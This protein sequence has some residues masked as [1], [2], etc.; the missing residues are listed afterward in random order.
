MARHLREAG[1]PEW[2]YYARF[3]H[4]LFRALAGDR[5]DEVDEELTQLIDDMR[6]AGHTYRDSEQLL[7]AYR[8]LGEASPNSLEHDALC[9]HAWAIENPQGAEPMIRTLWLL[10]ACVHRR[11]ELALTLSDAIFRRL[12]YQVPFVH[13]ADHLF[14]RGFAAAHLA[15]STRG[16]ARLRH[17]RALARCLTELRA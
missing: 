16:L 1:D 3:L 10:L 15:N 7:C 8:H 6:R 14:Y 11:F 5:V 17:V 4:A 12:L 2:D 13:V 9:Y